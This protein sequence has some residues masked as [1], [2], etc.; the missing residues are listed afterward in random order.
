MSRAKTSDVLTQW[1]Y[2]F[3]RNKQ[4][5]M[6]KRQ[7]AEDAIS[8]LRF[9]TWA[10]APGGATYYGT[11]FMWDNHRY[12]VALKKDGHPSIGGCWWLYIDGKCVP[13]GAYETKVAATQAVVHMMASGSIREYAVDNK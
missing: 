6:Q 2:D 10:D 1:V 3:H 8:L 12:T 11:T 9:S 7:R 5:D 13:V 4:C